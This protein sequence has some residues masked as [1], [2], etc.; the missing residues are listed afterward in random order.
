LAQDEP[1]ISLSSQFV[2]ARDV[3][4]KILFTPFAGINENGLLMLTLTGERFYFPPASSVFVETVKVG[5]VYNTYVQNK[6]IIKIFFLKS[7]DPGFPLE[8]FIPAVT[9]PNFTQMGQQNI[10]AASFGT[11]G[12]TPSNGGGFLEGRNNGTLPPIIPKSSL[13]LVVQYFSRL[14][15]DQNV[16]NIILSP[17]NGISSPGCLFITLFGG[18]FSLMSEATVRVSPSSISAKA[19]IESNCLKIDF[20]GG[21]TIPAGMQIVISVT[22]IKNPGQPQDECLE[23]H[24]AVTGI[25]GVI[26][27]STTKGYLPAIY[28]ELPLV[29]TAGKVVTFIVKHRSSLLESVL[30]SPDSSA[31]VIFSTEILPNVNQ[32]VVRAAINKQGEYA[33]HVFPIAPG[34]VECQVSF[35]NEWILNPPVSR[36]LQ[37]SLSTNDYSDLSLAPFNA[38]ASVRWSGYVVSSETVDVTFS[39]VTSNRFRFWFGQKLL[40]QREGISAEVLHVYASVIPMKRH[41][42]ENLTIEFQWNGKPENS[43][44]Q[45]QWESLF[46]AKQDIPAANL[47]NV[48]DEHLVNP[49]PIKVGVE[50]DVDRN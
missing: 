27:D 25:S 49:I 44:L 13:E 14:V 16:F 26:S 28:G 34:G 24:A 8:L 30:T 4:M 11:Y 19:S 33:A 2:S 5:V 45:V 37:P 12:A 32:S 20:F 21:G 3:S 9:N 48:V 35:S 36:W 31:L 18:Q 7:F 41:N 23:I 10:S 46:W 15:G 50:R 42:H 29:W 6:N 40:M 1:R 39:V 22:N 43:Y 38:S 47:W 17:S